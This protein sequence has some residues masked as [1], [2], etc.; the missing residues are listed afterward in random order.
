MLEPLAVCGDGTSG[1]RG[2]YWVIVADV[3]AGRLCTRVRLRRPFSDDPV[4][5][6]WIAKHQARLVRLFRYCG[7]I[8]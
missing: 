1:Q 8:G 3:E 4:D 6:A 2:V 5:R 7:M